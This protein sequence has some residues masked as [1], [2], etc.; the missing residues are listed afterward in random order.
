[1]AEAELD[2]DI[3]VLRRVPKQ[4]RARERVSRILDAAR[5]ELEARSVAEV[6]IDA[7]ANRA[8]VPVGSVYQYFESKNALLVAVATLVMDE[9]DADTV[10]RLREAYSMPWRDAIEHTLDSV[11][12]FYRE[13]PHYGTLLRT[14]RHTGEFGQVTEESNARMAELMSMHPEFANAGIDRDRAR[15]ICRTVV[16]AV[17]AI[18]DRMLASDDDD[19]EVWLA[20]AHRLAAG[21]IGACLAE[22]R[23]N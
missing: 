10:K 4:A 7:I 14:I 21:Y 22:T 17:N 16:T 20:E 3:A 13:R 19:F 8:G 6:T 1:M 12:V 2:P 5:V 15:V 23:E 9:A 11:F 18:Q